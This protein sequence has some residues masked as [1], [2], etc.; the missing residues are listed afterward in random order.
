MIKEII[1]IA[2]E[3]MKKSIA[4]LKHEFGSMKAGRANASMLDRIRVEC[5]GSLVPISQ[6]AN[7][8]C[9]RT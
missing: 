4:V 6:V 2:D 9:T 1:S 8:S 5:Y 3:K 7:I